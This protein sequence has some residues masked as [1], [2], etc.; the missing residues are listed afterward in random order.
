M[1]SDAEPA[2]Y[3][4]VAELM[5][6]FIRWHYDRHSSDR[7]IIDTYFNAAAYEAELSN[8]PGAYASPTGALLVARTEGQII[9]CVALK[10][11]G[12]GRCEMKRLF[13]DGAAHGIGAGEAL[14]R[15]I[16]ERAKKLGYSRMMLDTVPRQIEAQSLYRKLGFREVEPDYE[17]LPELEKWLVFME[18]D[19][20]A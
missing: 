4:Q 11:L 8:L 10:S 13:V 12:E 3:P 15:A 5:R 6:S 20:A 18:L 14:A 16:I 19:L 7:A 17:M 9:G 2:D 1:I